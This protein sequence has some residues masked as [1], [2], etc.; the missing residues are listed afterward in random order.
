MQLNK[1]FFS[2]VFMPH[3]SK[4]VVEQFGKQAASFAFAIVISNFV[5]SSYDS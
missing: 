2:V 1:C 3:A 4:V 5:G